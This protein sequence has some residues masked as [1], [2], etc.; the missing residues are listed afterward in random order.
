[1]TGEAPVALG[2]PELV[3]VGAAEDESGQG[4]GDVGLEGGVEAVLAGVDGAVEV[5]DGSEVARPEVV[6]DGEAG[7]R[8][9]RDVARGPR[10]GA[11]ST[12][13]VSVSESARSYPRDS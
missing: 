6:V 12:T 5:D 4:A 10:H 3:A 1:T 9:G 11:L 7:G 2:E 8:W 13:C